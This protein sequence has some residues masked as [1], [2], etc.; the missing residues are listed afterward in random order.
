MPRVARG[1]KPPRGE[2]CQLVLP[3]SVVRGIA[4]GEI[5]WRDLVDFYARHR[6][7]TYTVPASYRAIQRA[8]EIALP[9][10]TLARAESAWHTQ[11]RQLFEHLNVA[12]T[13]T[14]VRSHILDRAVRS[15]RET[16]LKGAGVTE[17]V[18]GL[19]D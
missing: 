7:E 12:G 10:E 6:C 11:F 8:G 17:S 13:A 4:D 18:E 1:H 3:A 9:A 15:S 14:E 5:P 16:Y 2:N 19:A